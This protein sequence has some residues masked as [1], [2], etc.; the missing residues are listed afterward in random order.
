MNKAVETMKMEN[1]VRQVLFGLGC[2]FSNLKMVECENGWDV[3]YIDMWGDKQF[4]WIFKRVSFKTGRVSYTCKW[5]T[6]GNK[7]LRLP[8]YNKHFIA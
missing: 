5:L 4:W 7:K 3:S 1:R 6:N 2:D 8:A